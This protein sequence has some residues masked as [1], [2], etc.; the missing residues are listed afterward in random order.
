MSQ[1]KVSHSD[2]K[3]ALQA[4]QGNLK[5]AE[6]I[7]NLIIQKNPTVHQKKRI[8]LYSQKNVNASAAKIVE[9][10]MRPHLEEQLLV[11]LSD[12]M[13]DA[14]NL[15]IKSLKM[16]PEELAAKALSDWLKSNGFLES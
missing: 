15:A 16:E 9:D 1:K 10:A 12:T 4:A 5:K 11:T 8:V 7:L 2:V 3:R 13:R 6:Q 14:L